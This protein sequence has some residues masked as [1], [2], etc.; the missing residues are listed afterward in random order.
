MLR[1]VRRILSA[2]ISEDEK[3]QTTPPN[4]SRQDGFSNRFE[5]LAVSEPSQAFLDLPDVERLTKAADGNNYEAETLQSLEDASFVFT[6]L[7]NDMNRM[8]ARIRWIWHNYKH[9]TLDVVSAALA[10]NMA[11]ELIR[12][13]LEDALPLIE[14]TGGLKLHL[15]NF[16]CSQ[17]HAEG[18]S[19]AEINSN[20]KD[21]INYETYDVADGSFFQAYR[22][23]EPLVSVVDAKLVPFYADGKFSYFDP[24]INRRT[25]TGSR[26]DA[27]DR[28][29]II[30]LF[31]ELMTIIRFVPHWT[32]EDELLRGIKELN[33]TKKV[34][35][36]AIFATQVFLD[37]TY[38]LGE[39]IENPWRE[40]MTQTEYMVNDIKLHFEFHANLNL[41]SWPDSNDKIIR[42]L[43]ENIEFIRIDPLLQVQS[44]LVPE[45][46]APSQ[47]SGAG[48]REKK[49][50]SAPAHVPR[51]ERAC[52]LPI[53]STSSR[54]W[55]NSRK[56][57][58][59][60]TSGQPLVQRG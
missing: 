33:E 32:V 51:H 46:Y 55:I 44:L 9:G 57:L 17:C 23:L 48:K 49:R 16:Y 1:E 25:K 11:V 40:V 26:K 27:D 6:T 5:C 42:E 38:E 43:W 31:T 18:F 58:G 34:P 20:L 22:L 53:S 29:L 36:Y 30:H 7:I 10:T 8:R 14:K 47:K 45:I 50:A 60:N 2:L 3:E 4:N 52:A 12:D 19:V 41:R 13:M 28:E 24:K 21:T 54:N 56:R 59:L 37:I 15:K 39:V 35:F